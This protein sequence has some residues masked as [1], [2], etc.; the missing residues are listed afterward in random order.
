MGDVLTEWT[1]KALNEYEPWPASSTAHCR[2]VSG[3]S[4]NRF[5]AIRVDG[6]VLIHDHYLA[7][8]VV[9]PSE[10]YE[11]SCFDLLGWYAVRVRRAFCGNF[12]LDALDME[13]PSS[14][15][16]LLGS[17]FDLEVAT[18][19]DSELGASLALMAA[20]VPN[21]SSTVIQRNAV[22]LR[23]FRRVIPEPVVVVVQVNGQP[24]R[25][26][27]DSGSL[28]DFI[29]SKFVH[30]LNIKV[31]ELEKALPVQLAVQGSRAKVNYG[32]K[33]R[34]SYQSIS[35][36]RYF[37]VMNLLNYDLILGTPFLCQHRVSLGFNPTRVII[38]SVAL[39]SVD[40]TRTRVVESRAAEVFEDRLTVARAKLQ[41]YAAPICQEASNAPFP[42]LRAINH[43]IPLKD[44]SKVYSWRPSRCPDALR[45]LWI[46]KRDAYLASGRWRMS[47]ARS[48]SPMLLLTKPGTG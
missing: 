6:H 8:R 29:S 26:L 3:V 40:S 17:L 16:S 47:T 15:R 39:A 35:E 21:P 7:F 2:Q 30:Q 32:C 13:D 5:S 20:A 36:D 19:N 46:E 18:A 1:A 10:C 28:A 11:N 33:A 27:L 48:T 31:C 34:M 24:A 23:D 9:V 37:D 43:T 12:S 14:T 38:G 25:A 42:P 41:A 4:I 45:P 44:P 22:A